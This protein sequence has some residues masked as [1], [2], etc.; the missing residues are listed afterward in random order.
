M[1]L[2]AGEERAFSNADI[3]NWTEHLNVY[4]K[5]VYDQFSEHIFIYLP[6]NFTIESLRYSSIDVGHYIMKSDLSKNTQFNKI[7]KWIP[8]WPICR[9]ILDALANEVTLPILTRNYCPGV[10]KRVCISVVRTT[11]LFNLIHVIFITSAISSIARF[12][13]TVMH[14]IIE[15]LSLLSSN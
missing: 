7:I 5:K 1:V 8:C 10:E 6:K 15:T 2:W 11:G 3:F 4:N 14:F 12:L 9:S 13:N